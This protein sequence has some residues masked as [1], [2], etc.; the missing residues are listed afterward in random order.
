VNQ[1][2]VDVMHAYFTESD[3]NQKSQELPQEQSLSGD[4]NGFSEN[5]LLT[6]N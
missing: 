4:G 1:A 2:K 5:E 3:F 6:I